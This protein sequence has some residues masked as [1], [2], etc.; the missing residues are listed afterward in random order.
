MRASCLR[1]CCSAHTDHAACVEIPAASA[2]MT[3][4]GEGGTSQDNDRTR[5]ATITPLPT[6]P[7]PFHGLPASTHAAV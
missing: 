2:G 5:G 6:F 1:L 3:E 4:S 7:N